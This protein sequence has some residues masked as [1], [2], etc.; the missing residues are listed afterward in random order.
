MLRSGLGR[1]PSLHSTGFG[2][3]ASPTAILLYTETVATG[4]TSSAPPTEEQQQFGSA[5]LAV[6]TAVLAS[7]ES[8]TA[9]TLR[10]QEVGQERIKKDGTC[11]SKHQKGKSRSRV[12]GP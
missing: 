8:E 3:T 7:T 12:R 1:Q 9:V 4:A 2:S 6:G 10:S 5:G 11:P